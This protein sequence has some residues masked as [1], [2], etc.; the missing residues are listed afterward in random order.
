MEIT[1]KLSYTVGEEQQ[2]KEVKE[3]TI[4]I[5]YLEPMDDEPYEEEATPREEAIGGALSHLDLM[6]FEKELNMLSSMGHVKLNQLSFYI[7]GNKEDIEIV[8][9]EELEEYLYLYL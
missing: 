6:R 3:G 4:S 2:V 1:Y 7:D 8:E 5:T 9:S